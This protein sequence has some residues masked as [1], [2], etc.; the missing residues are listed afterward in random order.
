MLQPE[1]STF[2]KLSPGVSCRT[3]RC[4]TPRGPRVLSAESGR[5]L[6]RCVSRERRSFPQLLRDYLGDRVRYTLRPLSDSAQHCSVA[7]RIDFNH[8]HAWLTLT[9][10][11]VNPRSRPVSGAQSGISPTLATSSPAC[12]GSPICLAL[13]N[14]PA[15]GAYT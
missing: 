8:F 4:C 7:A 14:T 13:T 11:R 3:P 5:Y 6:L 12:T 2:S 9:P 10:E 15:V 1:C